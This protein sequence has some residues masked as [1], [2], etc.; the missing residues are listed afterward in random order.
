[1]ERRAYLDAYRWIL[2]NTRPV[3]VFLSLNRDLD[4]SI[5][6]PA[7]R[8]LVVTSQPEFSNPYVDWTTR[9]N[10]A[11]Q[12]VDKLTSAPSDAL[13]ALVANGVNYIITAPIEQF[14]REPFSFLSREFAEDDVVIYRVRR[15]LAQ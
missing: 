3:D 5:V 4:L 11:S 14:D 1:M 2:S 9:S 13:A 15:E 7:D 8:K 6:G 12:I 10:T